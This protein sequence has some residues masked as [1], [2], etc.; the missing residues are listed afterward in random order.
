M[1]AC[2]S[3]VQRS[4]PHPSAA[5]SCQTSL[6]R[7]HRAFC[8]SLSSTLPTAFAHPSPCSKPFAYIYIGFLPFTRPI[9]D[10]HKQLRHQFPMQ[11]RNASFPGYKKPFRICTLG[12]GQQ[13]KGIWLLKVGICFEKRSKG[14]ESKV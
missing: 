12:R 14:K 4:T 8:T 5:R 3:S 9:I 13:E 10:P 11:P 6:H 7:S 1:P 2:S